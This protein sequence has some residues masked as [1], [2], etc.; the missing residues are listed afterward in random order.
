MR[1]WMKNRSIVDVG[2]LNQKIFL[3]IRLAYVTILSRLYAD[4]DRS[5]SPY[6]V[7]WDSQDCFNAL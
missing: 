1:V 4:C 3:Q 7:Q 5:T 6:H 2:L